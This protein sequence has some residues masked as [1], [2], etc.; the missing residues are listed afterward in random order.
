MLW[1]NLKTGMAWLSL[2]GSVGGALNSI[3][4]VVE[5][6][7][8]LKI[9]TGSIGILSF[10]QHALLRVLCRS[11]LLKTHFL[12][13]TSVSGVVAAIAGRAVRRRCEKTGDDNRPDWPW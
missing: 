7:F 8:G 3:F 12:K 5:R 9:I 10:C 1:F 6:I 11:R 2:D 13:N 4:H